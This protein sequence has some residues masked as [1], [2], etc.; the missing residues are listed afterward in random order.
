METNY[1]NHKPVAPEQAIEKRPLREIAIRTGHTETYL[2]KAMQEYHLSLDQVGE[3]AAIR[4]LYNTNL[5]SILK[6]MD[7][8]LTI[9]EIGEYMAVKKTFAGTNQGT[10]ALD[11]L[12][13]F[14]D[15]FGSGPL[16]SEL[17]IGQLHRLNEIFAPESNQYF[18]NVRRKSSIRYTDTQARIAIALAREYEIVNFD[19]LCDILEE[20]FPL[21]EDE[22]EAF[23]N[24]PACRHNL[25]G[26]EDVETAEED[27]N[28]NITRR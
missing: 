22:N 15:V 3:V 10:P 12:V 26:R 4:E 8:D 28:K 7:K 5:P 17:I 20:G 11:I 24:P 18:G 21:S 6:L 13:E 23:E 1:D 2:A 27:L 16:D 19:T 14:H 25:E 9:N